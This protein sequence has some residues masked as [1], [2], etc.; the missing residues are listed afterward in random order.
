MRLHF[1]NQQSKR[2]WVDF[3]TFFHFLSEKRKLIIP[4][5]LGYGSQGVENVIPREYKTA[6]PLF[7]IV[8]L[9]Y[10]CILPHSMTSFL[11]DFIPLKPQANACN[12]VGQ[13]L[14]TLLDFT[15]CIRLHT[16]L[17]VV[18]CCWELLRKV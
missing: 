13:Q 15:E 3:S 17:Q 1:F 16:L 6:I 5:H 10:Q 11:F 8:I 14:P 4:P 7:M 2:T 9:S 18:A 12:I